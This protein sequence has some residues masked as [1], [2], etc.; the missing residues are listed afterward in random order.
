MI[1]RVELVIEATEYLVQML[2]NQI[3]KM[4]KAFGSLPEQERR[5]IWKRVE[6]IKAKVRSLAASKKLK[7]RPL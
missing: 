5:L 7:R 2:E 1:R 4:N 6:D 3:D